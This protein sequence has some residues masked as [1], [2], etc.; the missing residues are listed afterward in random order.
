MNRLNPLKQMPGMVHFGLKSSPLGY[1]P[2]CIFGLALHQR[3]FRI[4]IFRNESRSVRFH[5]LC[6]GQFE[7]CNENGR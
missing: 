7:K 2:D 4:E 5:C 6:T 1:A 3:S